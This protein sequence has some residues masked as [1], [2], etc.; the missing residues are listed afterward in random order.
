MIS[1]GF[2]IDSPWVSPSFATHHRWS[3]VL[4]AGPQGQQHPF[5]PVLA[6]V[7][8]PAEWLGCLA[9]LFWISHAHDRYT[10]IIIYIYVDI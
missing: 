5:G 7:V 10:Y 2:P 9:A 6:V 4:T 8:W 3:P 1:H